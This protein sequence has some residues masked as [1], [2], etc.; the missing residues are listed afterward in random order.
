MIGEIGKWVLIVIG[1]GI[2]YTILYIVGWQVLASI[3]PEAVEKYNLYFVTKDVKKYF[4]F[5]LDKGYTITHT[6]YSYQQFGNWGVNLE[7]EGCEIELVQDRL[8]LLL[9]LTPRKADARD[10]FSLGALIYF[11][12]NGKVF[13]GLFE[14]NHSWGKKKQF[15]R[16]ANLL[17]EYH[18]K[19]VPYLDNSNP[20]ESNFPKYKDDLIATQKK[21]NAFLMADYRERHMRR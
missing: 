19:I 13:I 4:G 5:L 2:G 6:N 8:E 18:D 12:T 16:L 1:G 14:G 20:W 21:Y 3:A 17:Q 7:S 9:S 10:G 15:E 11:V